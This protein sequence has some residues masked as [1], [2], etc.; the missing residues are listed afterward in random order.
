[1]DN[2]FRDRGR[3]FAFSQIR[4]VSL[5]TS[6][7]FGTSAAAEADDSDFHSYLTSRCNMAMT[8]NLTYPL[9]PPASVIPTLSAIPTDIPP[10]AWAKWNCEILSESGILYNKDLAGAVLFGLALG[11]LLCAIPCI[12]FLRRV[13][14]L[15][16]MGKRWP[17]PAHRHGG[18]KSYNEP[19]GF[20]EYE[21]EKD[22]QR[23]GP[24]LEILS[25]E[26]TE[27]YEVYELRL[28]KSAIKI[29]SFPTF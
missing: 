8:F 17:R 22:R 13:K 15:V 4:M 27:M 2:R 12:V 5:R 7:A 14:R 6:A 1:M 24:S 16:R 25:E 21:T 18:W 11:I 3:G 20:P 29:V 28:D 26:A 10:H 9:M 19:R 23:Y